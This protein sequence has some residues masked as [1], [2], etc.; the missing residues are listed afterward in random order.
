MVGDGKRMSGADCKISSNC[1]PIWQMTY[2]SENNVRPKYSVINIWHFRAGGK[3]T[4]DA[5]L[6]NNKKQMYCVHFKRAQYQHVMLMY[7][8]IFTLTTVSMPSL[9]MGLVRMVKCPEGSPLTMRYTAFQLGLWGWSLSTTVKLVTTTFT[10]F[11]GTSPENY[12]EREGRKQMREERG[13]VAVRRMGEIT[14]CWCCSS[15]WLMHV[16]NWFIGI[17]NICLCHYQS[18][19]ILHNCYYENKLLLVLCQ[20]CSLY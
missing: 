11:S 1:V 20:Y 13:E 12:R 2:N 10:L 15:I 17:L 7:S 18:F 3:H 9:V 16:N 19:C 6:N 4:Q 14:L 5:A 8:F